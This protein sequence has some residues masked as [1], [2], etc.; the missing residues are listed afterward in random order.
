[1]HLLAP[2]TALKRFLSPSVFWSLWV[3]RSVSRSVSIVAL[4]LPWRI[5]RRMN[6]WVREPLVRVPSLLSCRTYVSFLLNAPTICNTG[7]PKCSETARDKCAWPI[8][9]DGVHILFDARHACKVRYKHPGAWGCTL[10]RL[11]WEDC[12]LL[13]LTCCIGPKRQST[14]STKGLDLPITAASHAQRV[15]AEAGQPCC[16]GLTWPG[17]SDM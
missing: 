10:C 16:V 15:I 14:K 5:E 13:E 12:C 6:S 11:S 3:V 4:K 2:V 7:P 1:M 8:A 9:K 17:C